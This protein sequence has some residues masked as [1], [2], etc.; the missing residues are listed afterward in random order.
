MMSGIQHYCFCRR[1]W[2][3]IHIE[4]Q[5]SDNWR[6]T[7][8]DIIHNRVHNED[9]V[10][11]RPQKFV[12]RGLRVIS[13]KLQLSGICDV[14]EFYQD[15]N[16]IEIP[17]HTDRWEIIPVEYKRGNERG[18]DAN[19]CQLCAQAYALEEMFSTSID[20]GFIY[21][22]V[23]KRREK[24]V[25]SKALREKTGTI[26]KEMIELFLRQETPPAIQDRHCRA[27]SLYSVCLPKSSGSST[28]GYISRM[29]EEKE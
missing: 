10:E 1:Q 7:A 13:T 26:A 4:Q 24:V 17:G 3:L 25:F 14:V 23:T 12:I 22:A 29:L 6:T 8:G 21:H 27:C 16:G 11:S 20:F 28:K 2:A 19:R 18:D 5:W 15:S 9:I